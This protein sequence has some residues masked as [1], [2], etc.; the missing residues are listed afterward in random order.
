MFKRLLIPVDPSRPFD[1][2]NQYAVDLAHRFDSSL[3]ATYVIDEGLMGPSAQATTGAMDEALEWVGRD[4]MDDFAKHHPDLDIKKSLAYGST[5]TALFQV[6]LQTGAAA[7]VIGG[8]RAKPTRTNMWG[9]V[10]VEIVHHAERHAFVVRERTRLPGPGDTIVVPFDGSH[11]ARHC[12][13]HV[14]KFASLLA[15]R[16]DLV[17]VAAKGHEAEAQVALKEGQ[18]IV[19]QEAPDLDVETHVLPAPMWKS[20]GRVLLN[21]ARAVDSPMIALARLGKTSM[22]TGRSRTVDWLIAHSERPVWV[23]R[24]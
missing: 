6:V 11:Y 14:V 8:F 3:V 22:H 24:K 9:S 17:T 7:V 15:C 18:G 21:H 13:P 10:A 2:A 12:L 20:K 5:A 1:A 23:V 4:A 19:G 16:L